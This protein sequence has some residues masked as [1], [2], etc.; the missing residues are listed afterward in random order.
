MKY[1][2][3]ILFT[4]AL[5]SIN[6]S[7]NAQSIASGSTS[8]SS[9]F[10]C[11]IPGTP[12]A[13]GA[14]DY[15][16]LGDGTTTNRYAPVEVSGLSDIIAIAGGGGNYGYAL[17]L[18]NDGTV[19]A[20][21]RNS[22]G[23]LG[24]G[25]TTDRL[26]PVQVSGL[27]GITAIAAGG[28]H[29]LFLKNDGTVWACGWNGSG[30]LGD[31]TYS[32]RNVAVQLSGLSGITAISGGANHSL[33]LKN[34]GSVWACGQHFYG[35][36]GVGGTNADRT[37]PVLVL[38]GITAIAAGHSHSL[39]VKSDGTV[40]SCGYNSAG[41]LG[42]GTTTN[43]DTP[44]Q[45]S[46]LSG[47][48]AAAGNL[49][50]SL[51]LK[52]DGTVWGC[53]NNGNGALGDGTTTARLTPV[54]AIGLPFVT[55]IVMGERHSV[56]LKNDGT[57]WASG[58]SFDGRLGTGTG[59]ISTAAEVLLTCPPVSSGPVIASG[60][61]SSSSYFLCSSPGAPKACGWNG[62][63]QLGDGTTTSRATPVAISG[64]SDITA[65]TGGYR[66]SLFLKNDG[67][68]WASGWNAYGTL[69]DG[70]TTDRLTPVQVSGLSGITAIAAGQNHSLFL[71]NDGTVWSCG[72]NGSGAL[73]DATNTTRT[74]PVQVS[75]LSAIT[76]IAVGGYH[77]LFLKN[78]G[79]VWACGYNSTGQLGDGTYTTRLTPVQVIG[80]SGITAI[81]GGKGHSLFLKDDGSVWACGGNQSGQL[82]DGTTISFRNIPVAV[83][84]LSGIS[85]IAGGGNHSLFL[86]NDGSVW[87]CGR[88]DQGQL[89]DGTFADRTTPVQVIGLSGI[90]AI[91]AGERHSLFLKND[92]IVW[93]CGLNGNGQFGDGTNTNSN[94]PVAVSLSCPPVWTGNTDTN[95]NTGSNWSTSAVPTL[96]D[97]VVIPT[98]PT[99][100]VFP[101][102][103]VNTGTAHDINI[104]S[105]A[106]LTIPT[107]MALTLD[108]TLTNEGDVYVNNSGS[109]VQKT[110]STRT[111]S[112]TYNVYVDAHADQ[113][114][115]LLSSPITNQSTV[116]GSSTF[117]YDSNLSTQ[118]D[119][120]DNPSDPGWV[121]HSGAMSPG[122]GYASVG[123]G[124]ITFTGTVNNGDINKTLVYH[125]FNG[126]YDA[127]SG[128]GTPFNLV[129]NPYPSAISAAT[130]VANNADING[131]LYFWDDDNTGGTGY[132]RD[133]YATWNGSGGVGTGQG[134]A[135]APNGYIAPV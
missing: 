94:V 134:A 84:G 49:S 8:S 28:A 17:F 29:S 100:G 109:L 86:K 80:L 59:H 13:C 35:Q 63:G 130:F 9:Y 70:T 68:V 23:Q 15:G 101:I 72:Y 119:T 51:F 108:G 55:A 71:K 7:A 30:Q 105:G 57:F 56:F 92:G 52:N 104:E 36:L 1:L 46:G 25:T 26:T 122:T 125:P 11:T 135:G 34:D 78:D 111:G 66:H 77:S 133:D 89:G 31:G 85:A 58:A 123:A 126:N 83:I 103:D 39:F 6:T 106:T 14:N 98:T 24:D 114:F 82:G 110:G 102:L 79:S 62:A 27:S 118:D 5:L 42:D 120:D 22:A 50:H 60:P 3:T 44:V 67:T 32:D 48:T 132:T 76:S 41:Q 45:V 33:F 73:G 69:G 16:Q 43:R 116:P 10:L 20:C 37:T 99:G 97:D 47:I 121:S 40:W 128:A 4:I 21:G 91:V 18:K 113:R 87:A 107:G 74:T 117:R 64:L 96:T 38:S 81:A 88:N 90:T 53:G 2:V 124:T 19:W 112:G 12:Q 61:N 93:A 131:T 127:S 129:G 115:N 54:Q 75:G 65:I 95:W